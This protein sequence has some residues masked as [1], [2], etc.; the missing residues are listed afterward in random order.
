MKKRKEKKRKEKKR[1]KTEINANGIFCGPS[2]QRT[3]GAADRWIRRQHYFAS[4]HL[5]PKSCG[6]NLK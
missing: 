6:E 2:S 1:K 5:Q 3:Q 4:D